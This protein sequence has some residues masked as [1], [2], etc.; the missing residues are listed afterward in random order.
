MNLDFLVGIAFFLGLA[1]VIK[2]L[3]DNKIRHKLI[4]K[5]MVNEDVKYLFAQR[6]VF[7]SPY[8]SLKWAF[9][10]I[11]VGVALLLKQLFPNLLYDEGVAGL[12]FLFAG[13]GFFVYYFIAKKK[14][15]QG[16]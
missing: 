1:A 10:L 2:I 4:D 16:K 15:D 5:N 6:P 7:A 12:M 13:I 9:V 14:M 3:S 11:G 8:A